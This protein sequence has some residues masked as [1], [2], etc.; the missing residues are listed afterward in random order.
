MLMTPPK[1]EPQ[2]LV[3]LNRALEKDSETV[4]LS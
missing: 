4:S 2:G 3:E 1:S